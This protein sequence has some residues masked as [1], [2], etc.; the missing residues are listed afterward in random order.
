MMYADPSPGT[1]VACRPYRSLWVFDTPERRYAGSLLSGRSHND[2]YLIVAIARNSSGDDMAL[3][4]MRSRIG[5][6][7]VAD[8]ERK[9]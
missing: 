3:V 7:I 1:F 2:L 6:V 9:A 5:W 8:M 4:V